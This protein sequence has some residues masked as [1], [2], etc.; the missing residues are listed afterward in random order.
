VTSSSNG[1]FGPGATGPSSTLR[2]HPASGLPAQ[3]LRQAQ[4]QA[5]V[6]EAR[7]G[8]QRKEPRL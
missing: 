4:R 8:G 7:G 5:H 3:P 2:A 6:L 1:F